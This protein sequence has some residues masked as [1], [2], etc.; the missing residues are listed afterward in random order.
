M[1]YIYRIYALYSNAPR[2]PPTPI[3]CLDALRL[4]GLR[5]TGKLEEGK[6]E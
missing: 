1:L 6:G 4:G 5:W 2:I 3:G